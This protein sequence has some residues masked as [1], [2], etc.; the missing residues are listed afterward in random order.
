M[1]VY[2]VVS[3]VRC[4]MWDLHCI[5]PDLS[6]QHTDSPVVARRLSRCHTCGLSV[7]GAWAL[8]NVG[9]VV[10]AHRLSCSVACGILVSGPG[11]K[12]M[13]SALQRRFFT[14]GPSVMVSM[15]FF[16][17]KTSFCIYV[18]FWLH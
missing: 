8:E 12:L 10:T 3:G 1:L 18:Y 5:T 9:L 15:S 14:I 11:I 13:L 6:L 2:L 7:C 4:S 16:F 17:F